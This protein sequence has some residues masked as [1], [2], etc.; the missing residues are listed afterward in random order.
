MTHHFAYPRVVAI[1]PRAHVVRPQ[2]AVP[3][4]RA[5]RPTERPP[6]AA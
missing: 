3:G 1:A 5:V 2:A 4:L 6:R